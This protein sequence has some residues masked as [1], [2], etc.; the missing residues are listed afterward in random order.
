MS[1]LAR[2]LHTLEIDL[3]RRLHGC[4]PRATR[5]QAS[6][7]HRATDR[8]GR[9]QFPCH[10]AEDP[11]AEAAVPVG[12]GGQ[13]VGPLFLIDP[14]QLGGTRTLLREYDPGS[15]LDAVLGQIIGHVVEMP[16]TSAGQLP[17]RR[18]CS[19][20]VMIVARNVNPA[21]SARGFQLPMWGPLTKVSQKN[22]V[23]KWIEPTLIH[24]KGGRA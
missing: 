18:D 12:T 22:T 21:G 2:F 11:F 8:T 23:T 20:P 7:R 5:R 1:E 16:K 3:H 24:I 4:P 19:W 14:D 17:D 9:E 13:E 6:V 15:A 10:A